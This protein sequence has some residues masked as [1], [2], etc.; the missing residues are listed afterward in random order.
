MAGQPAFPLL[1][2]PDEERVLVVA[3]RTPALLWQALWLRSEAF[4]DIAAAPLRGLRGAI[5]VLV[6]GL[7]LGIS[8]VGRTG[9]SYLVTPDQDVVIERLYDGLTKMPWYAE[10]SRADPAFE[11][12]FAA[13]FEQ[14]RTL[15]GGGSPRDGFFSAGVGVFIRPVGALIVWLALAGLL[16]GVAHAMGGPDTQARFGDLLATTALARAPLLIGALGLI[17]GVA[18]E[19]LSSVWW[20]LCT[21][22]AVRITYGLSWQRALGAVVGA[23][24]SLGLMLGGTLGCCYLLTVGLAL[25]AAGG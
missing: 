22:W 4:Q 9:L 14:Q 20:L 24:V 25:A 10:A 5:I 23:L 21:Y 2:S 8:R 12:Q 1:D 7:V 18:P 11:E 3:Q 15:A 19:T 13:L 17:P 16:H 6:I